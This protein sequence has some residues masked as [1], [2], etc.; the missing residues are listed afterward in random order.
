MAHISD[1]NLLYSNFIKLYKLFP[2]GDDLLT[3]SWLIK[4]KNGWLRHQ[5]QSN[6]HPLAL[7]SADA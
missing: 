3:G 6:I 2:Q 4:K 1:L 7:T 5:L